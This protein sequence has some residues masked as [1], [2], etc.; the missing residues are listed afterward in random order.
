MEKL[1]RKV[2]LLK[3]TEKDREQKPN[4]IVFL[5]LQPAAVIE[6]DPHL[7]YSK[8]RMPPNPIK[9]SV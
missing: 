8:R 4:G 7:H 2:I 9:L 1:W 6:R 3:V 5:M